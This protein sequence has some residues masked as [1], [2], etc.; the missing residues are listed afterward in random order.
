MYEYV[1]PQEFN[2]SDR[3]GNFTIPQAMVLG[4]GVVL[5]MFFLATM[6][7][8]VSLPISLIIA[9]LTIYTMFKKVNNIPI[10]EFVLVYAVYRT[11]PK[12]LVYRKENIRDEFIDE[13]ELFLEDDEEIE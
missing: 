10:Y 3:I 1:I 7:L 9:G 12:V 13:I 8:W 6:S 4:G 5:I 2:Q 11:M